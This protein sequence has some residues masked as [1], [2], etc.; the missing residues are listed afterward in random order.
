MLWLDGEGSHESIKRFHRID[1]R[2]RRSGRGRLSRSP[3]LFEDIIKT[4]T[5]CNVAWPNT[6]NMNE[7]LCWNIGVGKKGSN[8]YP[9]ASQLA[10]T[11]PATLRARCRVGYRDVRIVELAKLYQRGEIDEAWLSDDAN[12][13]DEV[14]RFLVS[15]PGIGPYAAHN[16]MQ[17]LGRFS[18]VPFDSE[19]VRH[20]KTVLGF[21]GTPRSIEKQTRAHYS[22]FEDQAFRSYW[23]E[24]LRFY[25]S[26]KGKSWT[27]EPKTTG[28]TFTQAALKS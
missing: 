2:W 28:R 1:S 10:R 16:I 4:V 8:A 22:Q 5:S 13:D 19:T 7:L 3:S 11:K 18:D 23:F 20:A 21:S 25:E 26:R 6:I 12:S 24:L 27:W 15:L 9:R 14:K 17:L